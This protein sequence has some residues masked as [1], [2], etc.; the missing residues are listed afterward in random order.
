MSNPSKT[1]PSLQ[2]VNKTA[3]QLLIP[4]SVITLSLFH[5]LFI[6]N[7]R[8]C[9]DHGLYRARVRQ[10]DVR[11]EQGIECICSYA[12]STQVMLAIIPDA[13]RT[14]TFSD[15]HS[16]LGLDSQSSL[17][18]VTETSYTALGPLTHSLP[19]WSVFLLREN[20]TYQRQVVPELVCSAC[21]PLTSVL[22]LAPKHN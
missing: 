20:I 17:S 21:F 9:P 18:G 1:P 4:P 8:A 19:D 16:L 14:T 2:T 10:E 5:V 6:A 7:W 13:K 3:D 22:T 12:A 11:G 15:C